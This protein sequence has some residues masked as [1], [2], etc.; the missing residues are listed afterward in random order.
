M[1]IDHE[2]RSGQSGIPERAT[3]MG[4]PSVMVV[5]TPMGCLVVQK[6]SWYPLTASPPASPVLPPLHL[7]IKYLI[8]FQIEDLLCTQ[9]CVCGLKTRAGARM[10]GHLGRR[11][12]LALVR[13]AE[14]TPRGHCECIGIQGTLQGPVHGLKGQEF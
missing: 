14:D 6:F 2:Q 11:E 1:V 7:L 5:L 12:H 3:A 8:K 4:W 13:T 10:E 9:V